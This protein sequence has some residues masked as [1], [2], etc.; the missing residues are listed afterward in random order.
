MGRKH[1]C[2]TECD[3][4]A[5]LEKS[6]RTL[7]EVSQKLRD[8]PKYPALEAA[9]VQAVKVHSSSDTCGSMR[10]WTHCGQSRSQ[11]EFLQKR[12][13][14]HKVFEQNLGLSSASMDNHPPAIS[15]VRLVGEQIRYVVE[16]RTPGVV[17]RTTH[18]LT[19]CLIRIE[20]LLFGFFIERDEETATGNK[21]C[22][23]EAGPESSTQQSLLQ[24]NCESGSLLALCAIQ[25]T[26]TTATAAASTTVLRGGR[27]CV[28][29]RTGRRKRRDGIMYG[30]GR[31]SASTP[32]ANETDRTPGCRIR[33]GA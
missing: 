24:R 9:T 28:E 12:R 17:R 6:A 32:A 16:M 18:V 33:L 7:S 5:K 14:V 27:S 26:A 21:S 15:S 29:L 19:S 11:R 30:P 20:V 31:R 13:L 2:S 25:G 10:I 1:C 8:V 22:C 3:E 23:V 4:K